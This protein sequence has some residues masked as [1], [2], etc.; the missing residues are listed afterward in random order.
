VF[1]CR[2]KRECSYRLKV[3][4]CPEVLRSL[5]SVTLT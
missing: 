1:D 4:R 5:D 2:F 3:L